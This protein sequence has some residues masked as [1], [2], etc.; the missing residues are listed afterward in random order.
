MRLHASQRARR[1]PSERRGA[2]LLLSFLVLLVLILILQQIDY[3]T[4]T[5]D[6]VAR[7]E[8]ALEAMDLAIESTML[9]V[10]DSLIADG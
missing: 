9:S 7:N 10:F 2:V 8:H 1:A 6:R 5:S 4:K 3:T